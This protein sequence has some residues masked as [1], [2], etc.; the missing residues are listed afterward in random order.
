MSLRAE[1][2]P[3]AGLP[4]Q[5]DDL[6]GGAADLEDAMAELLRVPR[7][8]LAC[9]GTVCLLVAL[10]TL[11][12][13]SPRRNRVIVPAYTCPLV[14][15]A[16][17]HAGLRTVPCDLR[18][19]H[20]DFDAD[21]LA[22]LCDERTLA[23]VPTHLGGRLADVE[24]AVAAARQCGAHVIEDAA[25]A[26]GARQQ[27]ASVGLRGDAGFFSLAAGKG[28]TTFEGGLLVAR[29]AQ[30]REELAWTGERLAVRRAGWELR[31]S[32]EL[33]G[34]WLFYRPR[35]LGLVHGL[36]RRRALA[37]GDPLA[38]VGDRFAAAIPQHRM[39]RWRATV[40]A[41]ASARLP[42]FLNHAA[43]QARRRTV[44]LRAIEGI[45]VFDDTEE[46]GS[47]TWPLIM[48][49]QPRQA[50][51]DSVM[52]QLWPSPLGVSRMFIHALPDYPQ[53]AG[54]LDASEVPRARDLAGRMMTISNSP[55]L[56]DS[57]F[58][59][60]A[61]ILQAAAAPAP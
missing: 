38:A 60:I 23:V 7:P 13:R 19:N 17:H 42:S 18:S 8:Q 3:T 11:K 52:R 51:R 57:R 12:Q 40:A 37:R 49:L 22:G 31:R 61:G 53:L 36:P 21:R 24:S 45:R 20:F 10:L 43:A 30:L 56:D 15:L 39:G 26:L 4:L 5:F 44:R 29:D 28:L 16:I 35:L 47:G 41:R 1:V 55:W 54:M 48:L 58:E 46:S 9:S 25:Q 34:Y 14:A 32:I 27:G 2:P 6:I 59:Q 50:Q 33:L